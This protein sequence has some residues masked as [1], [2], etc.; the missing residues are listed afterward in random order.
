MVQLLWCEVAAIVGVLINAIFLLFA[1]F[2]PSAGSIPDGYK[3]L[4]HITPQRYSLS[5][6]VSILFGNCPEDPTYDE[7][8]QT[9]I[10]VMS[11]RGFCVDPSL[12]QVARWSTELSKLTVGDKGSKD[13]VAKG[14][15]AK[16]V[17]AAKLV[18]VVKVKQWMCN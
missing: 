4:Y 11:P 9:Y 3:W 6:L 1:G 15:M 12:K 13:K 10:N 5:I 14:K 2:N 7:A 8:T 16:A 17:T 18:K